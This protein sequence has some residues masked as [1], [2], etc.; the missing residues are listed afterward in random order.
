[1]RGADREFSCHLL[2]LAA[3]LTLLLV[4]V[5]DVTAERLPVK[6]Y[7]IET[8]LPHNR[9]KR[10][11]QDSHGFLWFCTG[12]GLSRFDG[13]QFTTYGLDDGLPAPSINDLVEIADGLYWIATN[14][15]GVV[16]FDL[17]AGASPPAAGT[18]SRF[19]VFPISN[20]PVTNR[21]NVLY[22]DAAGMLWAGTD[23]GLFRL[24][25]RASTKAFEPITLGIPSH[26]EI[27]VQVWSI[28]EDR[29]R[30]LWIGT[31]FGLVRRRPDGLMT[32]Y[33]IQ[34]TSD[35]DLVAAL[36]FDSHNTL[37]LGHRA[38][39]I[40]FDPAAASSDDEGAAKSHGLPAGARHYTT[41][42]GLENNNVLALRQTTDGRIWIQTSSAALTEFDGHTFRT[43]DIA[44]HV[45]DI[46]GSLI[47]DRDRN[48][49]L[50]T[51]GSG[52]L[53]ILRQGWTT[54]DRTDGLGEFVGSVF[55]NKAG[56]LYIH[57]SAWRI[58]RF[59]GAGF[60]TIR[61]ALPRTVF[62]SIWRRIT[63]LLQDHTGDWWIPTRE[64]LYRFGRV[65]RFEHLAQAQPK[66]I[67][68]TREGLAND[69]VTTVF[70]DSRG[71]IW[72]ASWL[73]ARDV[74]VRWERATGTFHRYGEKDGL[75]PFTSG[76]AFAEDATGNI[77]AGFREGGLARYRN[78][79]FTR[80]GPSDGLPAGGVNGLYPDQAGRLWAISA[81]S[82]CRIDQPS[83]DRPTVVKYT[84]ADGLTSDALLTL[85]GDLAG[86]IYVTGPRGIDR[87]D[88][89]TGKVRH[90]AMG[91]GLP[92]G[93]LSSAMRDRSGALWFSTTTGLARL[94]PSPDEHTSAPSILIG[95]VRIAGVS[96]SLFS[97]GESAVSGLRLNPDQNNVQIDFF[98]VGFR[99][100]E[101]IRYRYKLDGT[102]SDWSVPSARRSVDFA[103]L[104][105][106]AYR[107]LVR[108]VANDGTESPSPAVVTFEVLPPVWRRWWFLAIAASISG[109][110]LLGFARYRYE[111][112]AALRE[113]EDRF[114]TLAETASDA[115]I[116]I[117]EQGRMV[118]VNQATE[119][120]FGYVRQEMVGAELT[121][122]MPEDLKQRHQAGFARY[123]LGGQRKI[124]WAA[125]S[126]P[127]L[128]RDGQQIPLEISFGE[129]TR[130]NRRFFTGIARDV[131][132]RQ[133]AE[134]ALRRS[135]EERL[136][137]LERVRKRIA[138]D[139]HDDVG[140]SLTRISLLSEVVR[141]KV[142]HDD[143]SVVNPL[144]TI[145]G[146]SRELVDSMSD[147]V[148][149]INPSRDHLSDLSQ[150]MRQFVSDVCTARQITV[151]FRTPSAE[152]DIG[153][154]ANVRREV[155]LLFKEAVN[156]M[157]R[158]SGC[159]E[160]DIDFS[161]CDQQL[162]LR[163]SDN[164][165]GF[166]VGVAGTGHGVR[167]MRGRT[168]ALGGHL[169][170]LSEAGRGT[171]LTFTI[172]LTGL[173]P[174]GDAARPAAAG[175]LHEYAV[176]PPT[177]TSNLDT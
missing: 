27:Q 83:A 100:G 145:A 147:I 173:G 2:R 17:R 69:D 73:Q 120:V 87:L 26:S 148:W 10:I 110:G 158:H 128:R 176:T 123:K 14:S 67:Y 66:A 117:D 70:E 39:L 49:W 99:A 107:F 127:G 168:E 6:A 113:S 142:G 74:L 177:L 63:S 64:G 137:E 161:V 7:A 37:W 34:P 114:R 174:I 103:S 24:N 29:A 54:Y 33:A 130:K 45:G 92:G 4:G 72:I 68:T 138:T 9:V 25:E 163:I 86:R 35:N 109:A 78:G 44:Q 96:R 79:R 116:T 129:F 93:E 81:G 154:G 111:R 166:D 8:G 51:T 56:E 167:S 53:K 55:E 141:Q 90:Y 165:C 155:F 97:L 19:T 122:L 133:R 119:K 115:I 85:T 91:E 12:N 153:V 76:V 159:S 102:A 20:E 144:T 118:F 82:L 170:V 41:S 52:A 131:T 160:A 59:D 16:Q 95:A 175:S 105:P 65:D 36:L 18:H 62:E 89:T 21:V 84:K 136:T 15:D 61:P 13:Y 125:I 40:A 43:Y 3:S 60:T 112:L 77:W 98:S 149:A 30:N 50:G 48:L 121:M 150:R 11:V 28:A 140:S 58:S 1:M 132:E 134:E 162:V 156:N 88:P 108:A 101:S 135:R 80:L 104:A 23:G 126:V 46:I 146:L 169:D 151:R 32:H 57:S 106:G 124:A 71:D 152:C 31:K 171:M 157:V 42:D 5:A 47:E 172:P 164:G 143:S 38:G 75:R 22:R 94:M 139:L